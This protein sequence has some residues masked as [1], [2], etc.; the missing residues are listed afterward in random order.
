MTLENAEDLLAEDRHIRDHV[1]AHGRGI[2]EG[3]QPQRKR[4]TFQQG[5]ENLA[6]YLILRRLDLRNIQAALAPWGLSPLGHAEG[7]V[8]PSLQAIIANLELICR[9][10]EHVPRPKSAEFRPASETLARNT[11]GFW[12]SRGRTVHPHPSDSLGKI[13]R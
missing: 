12:R 7:H 3:W 10:N 9:S 6:H 2:M 1:V 5:A 13:G 4:V 8:L 11:E